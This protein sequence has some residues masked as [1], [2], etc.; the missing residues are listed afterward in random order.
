MKFFRFIAVTVILTCLGAFSLQAQTRTVSGRVL[1]S[2]QQP[3]A[4]VAVIVEGTNNGTVTGGDGGFSL[5]VPS[6]DVTL[7]VSSL[8]YANQTV[9]VPASQAVVNIT[10]EEDDMLLDETVVDAVQDIEI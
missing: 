10:L 6:G 2:G 1:D 3:L 5:R 8:G 4:G 7:L 9:N